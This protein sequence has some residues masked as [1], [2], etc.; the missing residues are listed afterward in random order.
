MRLNP[1]VEKRLAVAGILVTVLCVI[2]IFFVDR[3]AAVYAS[4]LGPGLQ[5]FFGRITYMGNS[6]YSLIPAFL[7]FVGL[8]LVAASRWGRGRRGD[9]L[10]AWSWRF[11]FLFVAIAFSGLFT[12]LLKII[13]GRPRPRMFFRHGE[14]AFSYFKFSANMWSFP[15]GHSNT[16]F[17]LAT[18][19]F[20]LA[21]RGWF[22]YFPVA[23]L[24]AVSRVVVG[25][26]YPG[27]VVMGSYLGV[28]TTFYVR[29]FFLD[30]GIDVFAR[31]G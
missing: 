26:H 31:R 16:V 30:K 18:A 23:A 6:A 20:F 15:S 3:A 11:L 9:L 1:S 5:D 13:F 24:V 25:A 10:R 12:D 4:N 19:L 2:L 8:R 14:Y 29:Q 21:P 27:D 17:A 22:L 28:A 7:L